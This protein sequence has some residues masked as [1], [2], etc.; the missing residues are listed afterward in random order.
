MNEAQE[1]DDDDFTVTTEGRYGQ[2]KKQ[3]EGMRNQNDNK[4]PYVG[5]DGKKEDKKNL[6]KQGGG[7]NQDAQ[8]KR[9]YVKGQSKKEKARQN[10]W[11]GN[12]SRM[13]RSNLRDFSVDVTREWK[14]L[15][16]YTRQNFDR[17]PTL[18]PVPLDNAKEC[19]DV[20]QYET[21]WDR[22]SGKKPQALP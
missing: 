20:P 22:A 15:K 7:F 1:D 4:R 17:L 3:K 10:F 21:K 5:K 19:G 14:F 2:Q 9:E 12:N 6:Q 16:E 18:R 11:A 13:L 8:G